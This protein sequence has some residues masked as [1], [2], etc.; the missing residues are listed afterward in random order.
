MEVAPL[1]MAGPSSDA[2][3]V[4]FDGEVC[5]YSLSQDTGMA[6]APSDWVSETM[7][8]FGIV[9]GASFEGHEE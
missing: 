7:I 9:M 2:V 3:T 6:F 5:T 1:A 8:V 4:K